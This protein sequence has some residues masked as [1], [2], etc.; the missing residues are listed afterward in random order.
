[1]LHV[2][3]LIVDVCAEVTPTIVSIAHRND[4]TKLLKQ[5][6]M[7]LA[8]VGGCWWLLRVTST[9]IDCHV[10]ANVSV[11]GLHVHCR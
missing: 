11:T 10:Q 5:K 8:C 6:V 7:A 2:V 9:S 1:L 4:L 3:N